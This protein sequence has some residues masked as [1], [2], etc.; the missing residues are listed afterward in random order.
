MAD[1]ET[2]ERLKDQASQLR[3]NLLHLTCKV[4]SL[5]I[6]GDLSMT[7][8]M[9][10]LFQYKMKHDPSNPKWKE[11]D[12]FI[13]S[14]GHGAGTLYLS[15]AMSGYFDADEVYETYDKLDSPY[16]THPTGKVRGIEIPT[17]SLG[18]GLSI[19]VGMSIAARL[20]RR[21]HRI[22]TLMGDG[23]TNEGTVWEAA[24]AAPQYKLGNLV[25]LI[26]RNGLS[27]DGKTEEI[28]ALEPYADKWKAFRW[29]VVEVNGHDMEALVNAL[30][31]LPS[32]DS[33]VPTVLICNTVKGKGVDFMENNVDWH[34]GGFNAEVMMSTHKQIDDAR[35]AER[36]K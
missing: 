21:K 17:G 26:D 34:C 23:E 18:H 22:F 13:L 2:I 24:M 27:L 5:H 28:M 9:V 20:D 10:A 33:D 32:V 29:N 14:K 31:A 15:L 7:D 30:D 1:K 3:K 8:I 25:A 6:G 12:R 19:S 35:E 36:G 4:G 16:G 11:R